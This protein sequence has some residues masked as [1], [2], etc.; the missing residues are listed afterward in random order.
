M[1][2]DRQEKKR[3]RFAL[4]LSSDSIKI[5]LNLCVFV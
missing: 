4:N 5:N 3:R 1:V 2:K